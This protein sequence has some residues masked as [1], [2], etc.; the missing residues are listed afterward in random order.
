[1]CAVQRNFNQQNRYEQQDYNQFQ[2]NHEQPRYRFRWPVY[3]GV[4]LV[5]L[6]FFWFVS[7]IKF[8]FRFSDITHSL[9]IVFADRFVLLAC[10]GTLS[11]IA[12]LIIKA[13]R[14]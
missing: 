1:M 3:V 10:L 13:C 14:K 12:L 6:I 7:G 2:Q 5:V 8:A 11:V 9:G 4:P